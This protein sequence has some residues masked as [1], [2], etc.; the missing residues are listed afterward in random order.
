MVGAMNRT[1][2][3]V[4]ADVCVDAVLLLRFF[5]SPSISSP[6]TS[7]PFNIAP[8]LTAPNYQKIRRLPFDRCALSMTPYET[9]V[10]AED[11][12]VFDLVNIVPYI[13]K[14]KKNPITG[15]PLS[16]KSLIR[17]NMKKNANDRWCCP[18]TYNEFTKNSHIVAIRPTGNVYSWEAVEEMNLKPRTMEDLI[19]GDKFTMDDIITIQD[20][21]DVFIR[22]M[23][24][25]PAEREAKLAQGSKTQ[26]GS[27]QLNSTM[28][29]ILS[30]VP[31]ASTDPG[32]KE[33]SPPQSSSAPKDGPRGLHTPAA[34]AASFTSTA[35]APVTSKQRELLSEA[36]I[37]EQ[38]YRHMRKDPNTKKSYVRL[39]TTMGDLNLQLETDLVSVSFSAFFSFF[40][41]R[42][43]LITRMKSS[44]MLSRPGSE[45]LSQFLASLR[46]GL[47]RWS[48][49]PSVGPWLHGES[50]SSVWFHAIRSSHLVFIPP[51]VCFVIRRVCI[52]CAG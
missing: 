32:E 47:L 46:A 29:R 43:S 37:R 30:Q 41:L 28:Q 48:H 36:E 19:T 52:G 13:A 24:V 16:T 20:P 40:A 3:D 25:Y 42:P 39:R 1:C 8:L 23:N 6:D 18:I 5:F 22:D 34:Y 50:S 7:L 4:C 14:H 27:V 11:G 9:P 2:A 15:A 51:F 38:R 10:C 17:L 33:Q 35:L 45:N 26:R 12:T 21:K 49:L 31:G 44:W